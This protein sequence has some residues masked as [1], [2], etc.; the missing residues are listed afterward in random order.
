[1]AIWWMGWLVVMGTV[2]GAVAQADFQGATHMVPFE[3]DT[4]SYNKTPS[5]GPI[6][7]LQSRIDRGEV[8]LKYDPKSGW[9]DSLLEAL[10]ISPKSQTLVFFQDLAPA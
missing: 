10:A 6:A 2:A 7:R 4:I 5:T 1:M 3:E 8:K 9:R